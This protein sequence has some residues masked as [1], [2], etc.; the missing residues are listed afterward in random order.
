MVP[1]H[2]LLR[3]KFGDEVAVSSVISDMEG[4]RFVVPEEQETDVA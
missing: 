3:P 2:T 1:Y 4:L